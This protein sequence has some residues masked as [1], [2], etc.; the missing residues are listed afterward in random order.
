MIVLSLNENRIEIPI[1]HKKLL[2]DNL[3]LMMK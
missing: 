1:T 2:C 3:C